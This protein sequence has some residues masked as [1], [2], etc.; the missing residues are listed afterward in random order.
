MDQLILTDTSESDMEYDFDVTPEAGVAKPRAPQRPRMNHFTQTQLGKKHLQVE[1]RYP[2]KQNYY[3]RS[4]D[5]AAGDRYTGTAFG[6]PAEVVREDGLFG[7]RHGGPHGD[8]TYPGGRLKSKVIWGSQPG[9]PMHGGGRFGKETTPGG[10][11]FPG[12]KKNRNG[13]QSKPIPVRMPK[14]YYVAAEKAA[15]AAKAAAEQAKQKKPT[16]MMQY[17]MKKGAVSVPW[18]PK[19]NAY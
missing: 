2:A 8:F 13:A 16:D 17:M 5:C 10:K 3:Y 11:F 6:R 18:D 19:A 4:Y 9:G 1:P 15:Q 14:R 12:A 7:Y